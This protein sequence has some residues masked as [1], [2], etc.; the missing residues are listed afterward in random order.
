LFNTSDQAR[1]IRISLPEYFDQEVFTATFG[2]DF[3]VNG[4]ELIVELPALSVEILL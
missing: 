4:K 1:K 2:H 3:S